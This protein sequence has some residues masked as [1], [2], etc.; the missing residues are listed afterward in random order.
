MVLA[1]SVCALPLVACMVPGET[2]TEAERACCRHMADH[3]GSAGM[4]DSHS[5]CK[6]TVRHSDSYLMNSRYDFSIAQNAVIEL[7]SL[8][9]PGLA[10][11]MQSQSFTQGHSPPESPPS[12]ISILRI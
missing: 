10:P 1:I 4:P 2:V 7:P 9:L 6:V 12:T 8:H 11:A 5:C 3:C